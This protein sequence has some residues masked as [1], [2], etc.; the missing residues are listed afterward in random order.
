MFEMLPKDLVNEVS[1][2]SLPMVMALTN[3]NPEAYLEHSQVF[4]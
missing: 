3:R 1:N 2:L 4:L